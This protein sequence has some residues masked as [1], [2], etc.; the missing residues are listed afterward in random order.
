MGCS[1]SYPLS[2]AISVANELKASKEAQ[3]AATPVVDV[4]DCPS[5]DK[6][7][8][9]DWMG[10]CVDAD[11]HDI[12]A[13]L[14]GVFS[15][16]SSGPKPV[17]TTGPFTSKLPVGP[18][19]GITQFVWLCDECD[20]KYSDAAK[21]A[22]ELTHDPVVKSKSFNQFAHTKLYDADPNCDHEADPTCYSGVRCK[23]CGGWFCY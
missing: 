19:L 4:G 13:D 7:E 2:S 20:E 21:V 22:N 11:G 16:S 14:P 12:G 8:F 5:R 15:S 17:I 6:D 10:K 23:K 3:K 1:S 18:L 9:W